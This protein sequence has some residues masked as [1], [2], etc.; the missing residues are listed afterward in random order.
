MKKDLI[1]IIDMQNVYAEGGQWCC[2][3]TESA[4]AKLRQ[5]LDA[6]AVK[7]STD[8]I[9]TRFLAPDEPVG[10]WK[11]YNEEN[12]A[13]NADAYANAMLADFAD[14]M[15]RYPLYTK[16]TY[17]SLSIPAVREAALQAER[18]IVAGVVAECCVLATVMALIDEGVPVIYLTD[19]TAGINSETEAATE[20][21]LSGLEPLQ[22]K[23]MSAEQYLKEKEEKRETLL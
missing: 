19:A 2:P 3:K 8:V 1:L 7:E 21:V 11:A 22:I 16:S 5:L 12:A 10:T 4:A 18:V 6:A 15:K 9:F 23:R 14:D 17:S 13:V 20:L